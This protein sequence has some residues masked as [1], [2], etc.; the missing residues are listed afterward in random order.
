[1]D[2]KKELNFKNLPDGYFIRVSTGPLGEYPWVQLRRK[3]KW[4]GS[5]CVDKAWTTEKFDTV[6]D[7]IYYLG[8][9]LIER[10][11]ERDRIYNKEY[12]EGDFGG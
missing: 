5:V 12:V 1:M 10:H 6:V 7:E 2:D 4:F 11:W 3:L 9:S 8:N